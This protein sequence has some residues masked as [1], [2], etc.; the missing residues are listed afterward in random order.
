MAI[1][2]AE[3]TQLPPLRD[4]DV[5]A[6]S[7]AALDGLVKSLDADTPEAQ[8]ARSEALEQLALSHA[9]CDDAAQACFY[10]CRSL[11][12]ARQQAPTDDGGQGGPDL[13]LLFQL[14]GALADL[15]AEIS[16]LPLPEGEADG[17]GVA[18]L[19]HQLSAARELTTAAWNEAAE[20]DQSV[21]ACPA[22]PARALH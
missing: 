13:D 19:C 6:P 12:L 17:L 11:G 22:A 16:A 7:S 2:T 3:T 15:P 20:V 9:M 21:A 10:L 18:E 8:A 1:R 5:V 4:D 14:L